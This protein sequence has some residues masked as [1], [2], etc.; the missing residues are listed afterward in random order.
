M[1][2]PTI[3]K[4]INPPLPTDNL[5]TFNTKAF[6]A[7]L[8]LSELAP[9]INAATVG[10]DAVIGT[11][12]A[13]ATTAADA[14]ALAV[15]RAAAALSSKNAAA[16]SAA[17]ATANSANV[18]TVAN[19]SSNVTTVAGISPAVSTVAGISA[20]VSTVSSIA[21]AVSAVNSN[22]TNINA[23]NSNAAN[24]NAVATIAANV[25]AVKNIASNVTTVSGVAAN[26][27]SVAGIAV[28]VTA[29]KNI[30]ASVTSVASNAANI[31]SVAGNTANITA[32][33]SNAANINAVVANAANINAAGSNAANAAS[34]A[35]SA[36]AIV[37]GVAS[38]RAS[39]RPTLLLDF[40]STKQLDSRITFTRAST[41]T[42][43]DERGVMQTVGEGVPRFHHDPATGESLGLLMEEQ[44]TNLLTY[45]D[46][47]TEGLWQPSNATVQPYA[48][49]APD[50]KY[51]ATKLVE[52][53][54][55]SL[56]AIRRAN[57]FVSGTQTPSLFLKAGE[58]SSITFLVL[59]NSVVA[60][61]HL[62]LLTG[63]SILGANGLGVSFAVKAVGNGWY[64]ASII[65][66]ASGTINSSDYFD[67]R[68]SNVWPPSSSTGNSYTGDGVSGI[69][70]WRGSLEAGD[71]ATSSIETPAVFTGRP[72][73]ATYIGSNGLIQTAASGVARYQYTPSD[74]TIPPYL[75]LESAGSNLLL[76]SAS[77]A[78]QNTT[79]T[80]AT[81][82]LSFYGTG[83]ITLSG[84]ATGTLTGTGAY[85]ARST[86]VFTPTAGTITLTVSGTCT[87]AQLEAADRATSVIPTTTA[88]V[89]RAADTSTSAQV[90]RAADSQAPTLLGQ[91]T[92][93]TLFIDATVP[94]GKTLI[95]S[96]GTSIV[97]SAS[98]RQKTA[99]GY[100]SVSTLKSI[101]GAAVTTASGTTGSTSLII[102]PTV[103]GTI[104]KIAIYPKKLSN[105]EIQGITS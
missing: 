13:D 94:S 45:S 53:A 89:T 62:N 83:S 61:F 105:T 21:P 77:L 60:S 66:T 52:N 56:K 70:I 16:D 39:I 43:F 84:A 3:N 97:S 95:T 20:A 54:S 103:Y 101:D 100:N 37:L 91:S 5:T 75:L 68:M 7:F 12:N 34:S 85:P 51:T 33:A 71:K 36:A 30:A 76:N 82:A 27:T 88:Q 48:A 26:V 58:R 18:T 40:A 104:R 29:V 72:S 90:T 96:G 6:D 22:A 31:T 47:F 74:L 2:I 19:I 10:I 44:R 67:V 9:E 98:T 69:Y 65:F 81:H 78:T 41:A 63:D 11:I 35:A 102:A 23:V 42:V 14:A 50:G 80:A 93:G 28:D 4:T 49:I 25:T 73:T 59:Q 38:N 64:K 46:T 55:G 24:I 57:V 1:T 8:D 87:D 99:V 17:A 79:V 86:L 92:E 15:D 32:A